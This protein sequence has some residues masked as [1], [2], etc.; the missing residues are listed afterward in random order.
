MTTTSTPDPAARSLAA[1]GVAYASQIA[2]AARRHG[3]DPRLL[4]AVA[5]QETGGPGSNAGRNVVGDGGHGRGVFQIDDRFHDFARSAAAMDPQSNADYAAGL[6]S[7]LLRQY[8]GDVHKALSAYNAGDPAATGTVTRWQ[9]GRPLGYADSVLAHY[10]A[11]AG[12]TP[13]SLLQCATEELPE[14]QAQVNA[15]SA[16]AGLQPPAPPQSGH[17][18]RQLVQSSTIDGAVGP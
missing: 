3:I 2:G 5:A 17:S 7:G 16:F 13:Q 18:W 1:A 14:Q 9:Y 12:E 8:G 11:I 10:A 4:A 6:L 15:L